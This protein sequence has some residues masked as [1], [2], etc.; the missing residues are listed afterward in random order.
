MALLKRLAERDRAVVA[1]TLD[2][3]PASGL[4]GDTLLTA[5]LTAEDSLRGSDFS[6]EPRAGFCLMGACQ[7]CWVKLSDGRRVRACSTLLEAGVCVSRE[8]GR[9]V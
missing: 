1:F 6:G 3:Q 8:P 2:G 9:S 7:D 4:Q 5:V